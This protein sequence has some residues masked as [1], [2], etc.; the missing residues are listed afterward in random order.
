MAEHKPHTVDEIRDFR[1]HIEATSP[2]DVAERGSAYD[3]IAEVV[4]AKREEHAKALRK[5]EAETACSYE[6]WSYC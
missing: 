5:A 3:S 4:R 2:A 6:G 1:K